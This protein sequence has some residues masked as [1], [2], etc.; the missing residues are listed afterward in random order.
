[1]PFG[2]HPSL[3]GAPWQRQQVVAAGDGLGGR[4]GQR[5]TQGL[6]D[7]QHHGDRP[8]GQDG[9]GGRALA[10]SSRAI[11]LPSADHIRAQTSS[12]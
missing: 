9:R 7:R 12:P 11:H 8:P 1:M 5:D 2:A 6:G 4:P 3:G 10:V